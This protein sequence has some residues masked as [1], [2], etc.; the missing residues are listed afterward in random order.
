MPG[1]SPEAH[2]RVVVVE[3]DDAILDMVLAV[4]ESEDIQ[5]VGFRDPSEALAAPELAQAGL[6]LLD[7]TL[8][9]MT[10]E[11]FLAALRARGTRVPVCI[12]TAAAEADDRS[13]SMSADDVIRKPFDLDDLLRTVRQFVP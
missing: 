1:S 11:E 12:M 2:R 4:L 9:T 6:V 13:R 10:G 5:V 7:L 3:D 8:P